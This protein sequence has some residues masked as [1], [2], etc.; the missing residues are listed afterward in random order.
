MCNPKRPLMSLITILVNFERIT[1]YPKKGEVDKD[2]AIKM[3]HGYYACVSYV[4][5]QIGRVLQEL[6]RLGLAENTIVVL[7]GDHGYNLGDHKMWCKH[8][9]FS[10]SM[11]TPLVVKVPGM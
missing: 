9:T 8:C 4:D 3:L 2:T 1:L 7:W 11:Q 10:S 6:E 5:A